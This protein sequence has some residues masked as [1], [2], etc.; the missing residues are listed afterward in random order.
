M[1]WDVEEIPNQDR[2]FYRVHRTHRTLG[3]SIFREQEGAMSTDWEKYSTPEESRGRARIPADNGIVALQAGEIR[4]VPGLS[5]THTPLN[6]NRSH[7]DVVGIGTGGPDT[8]KR[9]LLLFQATNPVW[10]LT[11]G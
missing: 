9:R 7:A 5:L 6:E 3:P 11:I 2:V 10:L 1:A 4:S 8:T